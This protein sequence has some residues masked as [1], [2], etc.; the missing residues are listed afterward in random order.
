MDG[1]KERLKVL[2]KHWVQHNTEHAREFRD[3]ANR[4]QSL[5][6]AAV[7][8]NIMQAA[9]QVDRANQ[10]LLAALRGIEEA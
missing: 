2:L 9:E 8:E 5:G 1:D 7:A 10:H 3:W 6:Q 4:A